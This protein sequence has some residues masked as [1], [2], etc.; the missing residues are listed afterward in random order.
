MWD[1]FISH[2]SEDKDFVR[3]LVQA[4]QQQGVQVWYDELTLKLGD[5][6]GSSINQG[7]AQSRYGVVVFSHAFFS[8]SWTQYELEG[9]INREM[10]Q[11][12]TILPIWHNISHTDVAQH[13]PSLANKLAVPSNAGLDVIVTK[14]MQVIRPSTPPTSLPSAR[15]STPAPSTPTIDHSNLMRL[16]EILIEHFNLSEL[17]DLAFTLSVP[18]ED[19]GG[20]GK[21][22]KVR[23]LIG[24]MQR[25]GR[26]QLLID[27]VRNER[28]H[29]S[30]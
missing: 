17:K 12:K 8:K 20:Y 14:I 7:L 10:S 9:L 16:R 15:A 23:E 27:Y 5:T 28:P 1:L 3:Q 24:H 26:L 30:L 4:L 19:L 25:R 18:F 22:D 6:L 11:G 21:S 13:A 2:A 29:A